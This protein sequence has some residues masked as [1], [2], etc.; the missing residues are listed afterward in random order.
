MTI[1]DLSNLPQPKVKEEIDFET[2]LTRK[3]TD[4]KTRY[5]SWDA[6]VESDPTVKNLEVS[7]YDETVQRQRVNDAALSVMLPWSEDTDA[8]NLASFFN[9]E[10]EVI[11]K[12]DDTV[13]PPIEAIYETDDALKRRCLLAWSA[14]TTA[15]PRKSYIYHAL[16]SSSQVKDA[17]AYRVSPGNVNV[18]VLSHEGNGTASDA[19][20]ATVDGQ[21][22]SESVRPLCSNA[23][24]ISAKIYEYEITAVL[25]IETIAAKDSIIQTALEN[26]Q[27]YVDKA[28]RIGGLVSESAL[29][30]AMHIEGVRDVDL[31]DFENYQ[32]D[33]QT[34][35]YCTKITITA[36]PME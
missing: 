20:L 35:P 6:D 24:S 11:Q 5:L 10:R 27:L 1:I 2:I 16:S 8:D 14:I 18:V 13:T 15:G 28:H 33:N 22:T 32:A 34:A 30:A 9:L 21:I 25:D 29:D 19:L 12:A 31:G 23:K 4:L 7:A 26:A 17:D 36:K 3:K